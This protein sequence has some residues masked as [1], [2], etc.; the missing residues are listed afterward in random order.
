MH[1]RILLKKDE[2]AAFVFDEPYFH[3]Y[4]EK[5]VYCFHRRHP[6]LLLKS[7]ESIATLRI[8]LE[9]LRQ[10]KLYAKVFEEGPCPYRVCRRHHYDP[11]KVK[12]S[13]K[14]RDS[15]VTEVEVFPG[16]FIAAIDRRDFE[17][18]ETNWCSPILTLPSI[19]GGFHMTVMPSKKR[20]VLDVE[21]WCTR[22]WWLLSSMN[23]VNLMPTDQKSTK[24]GG[25]VVGDYRLCVPNDQ[26]L[27]EKVMTEAHSSPFT[28]HPEGYVL[29]QPLE[30]FTKSCCVGNGMNVHGFVIWCCQLRRKDMMLFGGFDSLTKSAHFLPI[31]KNYGIKK[32]G[33][34]DLKF[35]YN[36]KSISILKPL[37][38]SRDHSRPWK[39]VEGLCFEGQLHPN[40]SLS[41]E[42]ESILIRQEE[43]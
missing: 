5:F 24:D 39:Y 42:P 31:R 30:R 33:E 38:Q 19:S 7:E 23:R 43:S 29:L 40:M 3:E 9:I 28:I 15:T 20:S 36:R 16:A 4:L 8:C 14:C 18:I 37:V 10:K 26:A 13:P 35:L 25:E 1:R 6:R 34:L 2:H 22:F 32:L 41:E 27:R 17:G 11:S 21:L 12:L